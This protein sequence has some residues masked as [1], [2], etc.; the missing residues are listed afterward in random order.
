MIPRNSKL[1]TASSIGFFSQV[2]I[3]TNSPNALLD[4]SD[5]TAPETRLTNRGST[6]FARQ[7]KIVTA[8]KTTQYDKVLSAGGN[9]ACLS[10]DGSATYV[11]VPDNAS[12]RFGAGAFSVSAWIKPPN[13]NQNGIIV[14]KRHSAGNFEQWVFY[15]TDSSGASTGKRLAFGTYDGNQR[16]GVT[17]ADIA[18][19]N[20]HHVVMTYDGTNIL[21]Y[22]DGASVAFTYTANSGSPNPDSSSA[23][24]N[25]G[26]GNPI[27]RYLG[28]I[29]DIRIYASKISSADV[30]I[31][32]SGASNTTATPVGWWKFNEGTGTTASDSQNGFNG[33][34]SG[35]SLP[36]WTTT[37][38]PTQN[39]GPAAGTAN[40]IV[41]WSSQDG[42]NANEKCLIDFGDVGG[43]S[44]INFGVNGRV[45][46]L[47]NSIEVARLQ[48]NPGQ[49][50]AYWGFGTA[51]AG[52]SSP[53]SVVH[54]RSDAVGV[55]PV[56]SQAFSSSQTANLQEW[57]DSSGN[58]LAS[59]DGNLSSTTAG[60]L[61]SRCGATAAGT[62]FA[63][64]GGV[65]FDHY[66]D[67]GSNGTSGSEADLYSDS[68]PA[69]TLG[70]NGDKLQATYGCT[71]AN[72]T[73]TKRVKIYFG[74]TAIFDSGAL[75]IS[76]SSEI[77]LYVDIIRDSATT[78]RYAISANT[79]GAST[80][81]FAATGKLT[82][83]TLSNANILKITGLSTN[84]IGSDA[85]ANDVNAILGTVEWKPAA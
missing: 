52:T 80:G 11:T 14:S 62:K 84:V 18:D 39:P 42:S 36:A 27:S 53:V 68:I 5:A 25:F 26:D 9:P 81:S 1:G 7:T 59:I 20:W 24:L 31:I 13:S 85:A 2:A 50:M 30:S 76:A 22:V 47:M 57:R 72:T 23:P 43:R 71:L 63:R 74:G 60:H 64:I 40:E 6:Y 28:Y 48:P 33:T 55:I 58:C 16:T 4:I 21:L 82:G 75:T 44:R 66:A 41:V 78:I 37:G 19:G 49:T 69:S 56:I 70:T 54:I 51:Y 3:G 34:L 45:D 83:L 8:D 61:N 65:I 35:S 12:L 73:S 32:Y 17:N 10:F 79:S 77:N 15:I 67:T 29:D 38:L 46:F